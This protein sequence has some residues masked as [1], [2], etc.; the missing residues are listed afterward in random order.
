[1]KLPWVWRLCLLW[2]SWSP[3][4]ASEEAAFSGN[5]EEYIIGEDTLREV[6][7]K[8]DMDG[9]GKASAEEIKAY[10]HKLHKD[11][12]DKDLNDHMEW[13]DISRDGKLSYDEHMHEVK[14]PEKRLASGQVTE[15][16]KLRLEERRQEEDA[17]FRKADANGD[18]VLEDDEL[19]ALVFPGEA[20]HQAQAK[21][22]VERG[23]ANGDGGLDSK[24]W[25]SSGIPDHSPEAHAKLDKNGDGLLH[26]D[27]VRH[28]LSGRF[29][30]DEAAQ[31]LVDFAD[32]DRDRHV[33]SEELLE[34]REKLPADVHVHLVEWAH[35]GPFVT[36]FS[37][38]RHGEL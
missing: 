18:E 29:H 1:M 26:L 33:S 7:G 20:A 15:R 38:Y 9:N 10:V 16:E 22:M 21:D 19:R 6:H 4:V 2:S 36:G 12:A 8:F 27:E 32:K 31:K 13:Y 5:E 14:L 28:Y 37:L 23:D 34:A 30:S 11:Q 35:F 25:L 3:R 17:R 24:E